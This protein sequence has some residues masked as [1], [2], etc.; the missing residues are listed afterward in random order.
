MLYDRR[1]GK[2]MEWWINYMKRYR[3]EIANT[4]IDNKIDCKDNT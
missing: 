3:E 2:D 4:A 1:F